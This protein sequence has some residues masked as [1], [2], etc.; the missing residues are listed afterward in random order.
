VPADYREALATRVIKHGLKAN[1][2]TLE[3]AAKYSNQ[4]GLTPRIMSMDE[5]FASDVLDS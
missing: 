3:T 1:R 4:Q 2:E 5:L